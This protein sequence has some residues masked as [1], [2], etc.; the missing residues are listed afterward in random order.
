MDRVVSAADRFPVCDNARKDVPDLVLG[1]LAD[2]VARIDNDRDAV[3]AD[4]MVVH[5]DTAGLSEVG[6]TRINRSGSGRDVANA[7]DDT[8]ET[9]SGAFAFEIEF[10]VGMILFEFGD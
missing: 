2:S 9:G 6:F 4:G 7:S 10:G 5:L 3:G 1:E 8:G